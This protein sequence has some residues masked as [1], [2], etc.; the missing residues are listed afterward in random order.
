VCDLV[1]GEHPQR[2]ERIDDPSV[3]PG[4][5]SRSLSGGALAASAG[6][7]PC[8]DIDELAFEASWSGD[9]DIPAP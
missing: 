1:V 8:T 2:L 4:R 3:V 7:Q 5:R 6:H 9:D